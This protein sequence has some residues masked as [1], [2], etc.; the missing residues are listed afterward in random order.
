MVPPVIAAFDPFAQAIAAQIRKIAE[1]A[2]NECR[3]AAE[4]NRTLAEHLVAV[5]TKR[6]QFHSQ[7]I[8]DLAGWLNQTAGGELNDSETHPIRKVAYES[9]RRNLAFANR[10]GFKV[11]VLLPEGGE[12]IRVTPQT[13]RGLSDR[14]GGTV[15][16]I[17]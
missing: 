1:A 16:S 6:S 12:Y 4:D 14:A 17:D 11:E 9:A 5:Y 3:A 2:N 13:M 8:Q 7:Q 10:N 15:V